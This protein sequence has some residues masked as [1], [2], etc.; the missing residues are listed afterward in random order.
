M[1]ARQSPRNSN[2]SFAEPFRPI[3]PRCWHRGTPGGHLPP[4]AARIK[5]ASIH[6]P[7]NGKAAP[8][9]GLFV[10]APAVLKRNYFLTAEAAASAALPAASLAASAVAAAAPATAEAA[11][12]AAAATAEAAAK[13]QQPRGRGRGRRQAGPGP[14]QPPALPSCRKRPRATAA[15]RE[16]NRSDLFICDPRSSGSCARVGTFQSTW[17]ASR[18]RPGQPNVLIVCRAR[19]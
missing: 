2:A 13:R 6:R 7:A 5:P 16:A 15:T 12:S 1:P 14:G 9:G 4:R 18:T 11:A 3:G 8:K 10:S 19:A 17:G